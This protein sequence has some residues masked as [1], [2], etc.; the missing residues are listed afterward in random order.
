MDI[1]SIILIVIGLI[2]FE[3]ISSIDN[4]VINAEVL[5]TMSMR[6]RRWF[7]L[8]GLL[9]AVFVVRGM[10]PW[11]IVWATNPSLGPVGALTATFSED[12]KIKEMIEDSAPFLLVGGGIFLIFLFFHWLF[13]EAKNYGLRGERFFHQ[14]GVWFF[15]IVSIILTVIVW[16][17]L[18]QHPFMAFGAVVGSTAFFITHGFK[19][20]AEE[21]EKELVGG[22]NMSDWSKILYLEV[23]DATFSIDGVV[24]AFAFTLSVPLILIGNGIGAFVVRQLTVSNIDN[25]KRYIYLKNGAMYSIFFLG[26]TMVLKS[27]GVVVQEWVSPLITIG[28][29]GYFFYKSRQCL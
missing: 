7:L 8:Y 27:F 4:A 13:I 11:L 5:S 26:I 21:H 22:T 16:F 2:L 9:F 28:V 10:L 20:N 15:A 17:A 12:P 3:T 1:F 25:I 14:H 6:A 19:Q 24:G 23:I 29:I 18:K